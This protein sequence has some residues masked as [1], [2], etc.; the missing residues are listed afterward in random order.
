ML[1]DTKPANMYVLD[2]ETGELAVRDR[3][4]GRSSARPRR[5]ATSTATGCPRS[6]RSSPAAAAGCWRFEHDGTP[7]VDQRRDLGARPSPARS[8]WPTSTTTA[9]SR[10]SRAIVLYDHLGHAE[11]GPSPATTS[12]APRRRPTSTATASSR[13]SRATAPGTTTAPCTSRPTDRRATSGIAAYPQIANLDDDGAARGRRSPVDNGIY[14][15]EHDGTAGLVAV[16]PDRRDQ[17]LEPPAQ[18]PRLRRR[19]GAR[20]RG[21]R[22]A[23]HYG[24]YESTRPRLWSA[25]IADPSGQAGGTA[26]DFL[27]AGEAEA[28]YADETQ[29]VRVRRGRRRAAARRPAQSGTMIEYPIVA[30]IDNDGSAE[31]VVVSNSGFGGNVALD[32]AGDPRRRR[33]LDPGPADLESAHLSRD[34]RA[35][36]RD[37][38]AVRAAELGDAQHV[39]DQ[40]ADRGRAGCACP[41]RRGDLLPRRTSSSAALVQPG[42]AYHALVTRARPAEAFGAVRETTRWVPPR[43]RSCGAHDNVIASRDGERAPTP[44]DSHRC[45][46]HRDSRRLQFCV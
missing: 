22:P 25:N 9:T 30:D 26:F 46:T 28:M 21:Q 10:S 33:S 31:I 4:A 13:S 7:Q 41:S 37:H 17:R 38:P 39:P 35:R 44:S 24:V 2:G 29:P 27:G 45:A 32:R 23:G 34:Q 11:S 14:L 42:L 3:R 40:R 16:S 1:S 43:T 15:L 18:H 19:R 36:G 20:V 8:R 6:S 12:T 5:S